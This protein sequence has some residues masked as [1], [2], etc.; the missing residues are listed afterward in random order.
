[1]TKKKRGFLLFCCSM[2][3]GAGEMYMGFFKRGISIMALFWGIAAGAAWINLGPL[4]FVLPVLWFY[5][6]FWVHN[7]KSL[8]DEEFYS[9]ADDY[10]LHFDDGKIKN[11]ISGYQGR[12]WIAA[13]LILIGASVIWGEISDWMISILS[14]LG[15]DAEYLWRFFNSVPQ[16]A[17]AV[18]MILLGIRLIKGKKQQLDA[19]EEKETADE[20]KVV[21]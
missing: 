20:S 17:I 16:C 19:I 13:I 5:S 1:M 7:M 12:K 4:L 9:I 3:P 18:L 21:D 10:V 6:F 14:M 15:I 11:A 8:S 2:I